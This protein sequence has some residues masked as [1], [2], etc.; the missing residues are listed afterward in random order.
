MKIKL[1]DVVIFTF[2]FISSVI[3][4]YKEFLVI[5]SSNNILLITT[6]K[7]SY[8][9]SLE[10]NRI[11][12]IKGKTGLTI[13]EIKDRKFRFI[14]SDCVNKTCVKTG[15]VGLQ[16]YPIICLPNRVSAYI[17]KNED[18]EFDIITR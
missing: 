16:N 12:Q 10:E 2:F 15:W 1:F 11:I 6:E 7:E 13:I 14:E 18:I 9:Y 8:K 17:I 5:K 4:F 3:I